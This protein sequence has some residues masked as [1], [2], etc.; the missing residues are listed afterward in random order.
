ML[1]A[2]LPNK[3]GTNDSIEFAN[4]ICS[5]NVPLSPLPATDS[6]PSSPV[7]ILSVCISKSSNSCPRFRYGLLLIVFF[8]SVFC[9]AVKTV[10]VLIL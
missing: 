10:L 1:S 2:V 9:D 3:E 7:R 5:K 8:K 6:S 4:C